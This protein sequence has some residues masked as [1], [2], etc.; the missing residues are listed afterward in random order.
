MEWAAYKLSINKL[1]ISE[2]VEQGRVQEIIQR[3]DKEPGCNC[4]LSRGA[5]LTFC[6]H[7]ELAQGTKAG[8][9]RFD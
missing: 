4:S 3:V 8:N 1:N 6:S 5:G 2:Q 7:N 9:F